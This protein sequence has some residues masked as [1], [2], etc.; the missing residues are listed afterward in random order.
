MC[1]NVYIFRNGIDSSIEKWNN[2]GISPV[3]GHLEIAKAVNR[4]AMGVDADPVNLIKG[5]LTMGLVDGYS[6]LHMATDLQDILFG[7]PELVKAEYH[8]GV[9]KEDYV[10]IAVHG[11][12]PIMAEKVVEWAEKVEEQAIQ[13]GAKGINIVGICCTANE[14]LMRK[15]IS[16]ATNYASQ[17]L[18]IVTG[19]LDVLITDVQCIMPG[20][21]QAAD[22]YHTELIS[23]ISYAKVEGASYVEFTPEKADEFAQEIV[24]RALSRYKMRDSYETTDEPS[25][26]AIQLKQQ[27]SF[28]KGLSKSGKL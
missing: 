3:N 24:R 15:G 14:L 13:L 17:E 16:V 9:I 8:L 5:I 21:K 20:L 18:A 25:I 19:A 28:S 2:L 11:H 1:I 4:Q 12:M 27:I 26:G 7:T 6:G 10:N 23:T 22:C